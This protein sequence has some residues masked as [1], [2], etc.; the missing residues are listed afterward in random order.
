MRKW[1]FRGLIVCGGLALAL[2]ALL[3]ATPRATACDGV[4]DLSCAINPVEQLGAPPQSASPPDEAAATPPVSASR[5]ADNPVNLRPVKRTAPTH[6]GRKAQAHAKN[7]KGA[8]AAHAQANEADA[9][10]A[11]DEAETRSADERAKESSSESRR[12]QT[13]VKP[14]EPATDAAPTPTPDDLKIVDQAEFNEIDQRAEPPA[15]PASDAVQAHATQDLSALAM[16]ETASEQA[17]PWWSDLLP[18]G[19]VSPVGQFF[20]LAG[21]LLTL[22]SVVRLFLA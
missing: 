10:D 2:P 21:G 5:R 13:F 17:R 15:A 16:M 19:D 11:D 18:F 6:A 7:S 12:A 8:K 22:A 4:F 1:I 3:T 9:A 14:A 20:I